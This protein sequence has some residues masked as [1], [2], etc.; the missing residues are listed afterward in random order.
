[1]V[2][3]IVI[4]TSIAL[5]SVLAGLN[6]GIKRLSQFNIILA[7]LLLLAVIALGPTLYI[8]RSMFAALGSYFVKIVPLSNW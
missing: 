2:V 8:F 7:L 3:L 5:T 6:V 4:I 1:M